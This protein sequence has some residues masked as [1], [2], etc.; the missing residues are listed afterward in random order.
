[1]KNQEKNSFQI[2]GEASINDANHISGPSRTG[3]GLVLSI[4][5]AMKE[6]NILSNEIDY[7]SAHGTATL[8]N[9]EME[10]IAFNR[11]QMESLQLNSFKAF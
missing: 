10:A 4:E 3:E 9:D 5:S 6:A 11:L 2:L 1:S 7:I 8:Y